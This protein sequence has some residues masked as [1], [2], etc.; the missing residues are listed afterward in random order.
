MTHDHDD[1]FTVRLRT[2]AEDPAMRDLA[3]EQLSDDERQRVL[4]MEAAAIGPD[5]SPERLQQ[6]HARA[7]RQVRWHHAMASMQRLGLRVLDA[8]EELAN[9]FA[10]W[11]L[12]RIQDVRPAP[13]V[14]GGDDAGR[15]KV[16]LVVE[17]LDRQEI[18]FTAE[19]EESRWLG[20]KGEARLVVLAPLELARYPGWGQGPALVVIP[21][22]RSSWPCQ[23]VSAE[24]TAEHCR[25]VFTLRFPKRK[26]ADGRDGKGAQA[27][28]QLWVE[29]IRLFPTP[30]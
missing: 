24:Q 26:G 23:P 1:D 11:L 15:A 29:Q 21:E 13:A 6:I 25:L 30:W 14:A 3:L 4:A 10:R 20:S 8:T 27:P 2:L 12:D 17:D 22:Q 28:A 18:G 7:M 19:V 5:P 16:K 9:Q